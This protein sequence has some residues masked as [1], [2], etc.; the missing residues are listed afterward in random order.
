SE[1]LHGVG[2]TFHARTRVIKYLHQKC[3]FDVLAFESGLYDCKK[4]WD[5]LR[6]GKMPARVAAGQGIFGIWTDTEELQPMFSYLGKQARQAKPLEVCGFDC[7][8]SGPASRRHLPDDLAVFL[9]KLPAQTLTAERREIVI[10]A[11]KKLSR[12]GTGIEKE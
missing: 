8:F 3:G 12:P 2:A 9:K 11:F 6:E 5:F 7:Q 1:E 10:G 4:A